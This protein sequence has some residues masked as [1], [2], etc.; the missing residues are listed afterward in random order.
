MADTL[1]GPETEE[2]LAVSDDELAALALAADPDVDVDDDA[3]CLWD[4]S[5]S[6]ATQPLP[7]WYMPS[8]VGGTARLSGWR[9][10][11]VA[12]IIVSF[13]AIN[14]FGLCSTYGHV[15]FGPSSP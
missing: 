1:A 8:A 5:G 7:R 12:F 15:A 10:R 14:A 4:L 9:R 11:T 3:I 6:T 2:A 13:L